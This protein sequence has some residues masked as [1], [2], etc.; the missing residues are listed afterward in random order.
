L[1]RFPSY[2]TCWI[3]ISKR[4]IVI[5]AQ[6]DLLK[7]YEKLATST[8]IHSRS[9]FNIPMLLLNHGFD[10]VRIIVI[11]VAIGIALKFIP[12]DG[13]S[14]Y[15]HLIQ[16][17]RGYSHNTLSEIKTPD[18]IDIGSFAEVSATFQGSVKDGF[19]TCQI[20]DC[21][22]DFNYWCEDKTTVHNL[23]DG[24]QRGILNF[25]KKKQTFKWKIRPESTRTRGRG[26]LRIAVYETK[27]YSENG[28]MKED[29]Q[30]IAGPEESSVLLT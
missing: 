24:R 6:K 3:N 15:S 1:I 25:K 23:G 20:I 21:M 9:L 2:W 4:K 7:E 30:Y 28:I 12:I 11:P 29:R 16:R 5:T 10:Y 17:L 27:D 14:I 18:K 19:I 22:G 26:K 13:Q 8:W